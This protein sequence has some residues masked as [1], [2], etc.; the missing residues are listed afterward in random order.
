MG[1]D[2]SVSSSDTLYAGRFLWPDDLQRGRDNAIECAVYRDG[3]LVAPVSGSVS[4]YSGSAVALVD[5][6]AVVVAE[7]KA[8]YTVSAATVAAESVGDGWRIEWELLMPDG[9]THTFRNDA[10][11]ARRRLYPVVTAADL[12]RRHPDLDPSDPA[13][14]VSAGTTHQDHLDEA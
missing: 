6:A 10:A 5:A 9:V 13:T 8:T 7:S 1:C 11:L 12:Y 3:A 14:L 2:L 4:V